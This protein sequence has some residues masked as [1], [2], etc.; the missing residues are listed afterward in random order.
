MDKLIAFFEIPA[1]D[2]SRAVSFYE[3]VLGVKLPVFDCEKEKMAFFSGKNGE[4]VGAI[5]YAEG[6]NPSKDGTLIHFNCSDM[7]LTHSL[8]EKNG[9]KVIT[10]KTKIE[11]EGRGY[12]SLFIDSEGN[13]GGLYT[14]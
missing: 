4:C 5:S 6:F 1:A 13:R 7:E 14:D 3:S 11:A 10:P 9:G 8:I 12:F 2:F